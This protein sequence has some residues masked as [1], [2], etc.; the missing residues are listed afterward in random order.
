MILVGICGPIGSGKTTFAGLLTQVDPDH[1][2]HLETSG[3][4]TELANTF[5]TEL[6]KRLATLLTEPSL[7]PLSNELIAMLLPQLSNMAGKSISLDMVEI[8]AEDFTAHPDWY[9]KLFVYL[10]QAKSDPAI[11][12]V[13]ITITNKNNYRPLLQWIGGYFLYKLNNRLL[14]YEELLRRAKSTGPNM[15]I[16]AMTAPRQPA[17]AEFIQ[18]AGGKVFKIE[19]PGLV[20]DASDVTERHVAEIIPDTTITNDG[21]LTDLQSLAGKVHDDLLQDTLKPSYDARSVVH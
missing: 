9:E 19:R 8:T 15:Q 6:H 5:N 14:W 3:V 12:D 16:I 21:S 13:E 11:L 18:Q 20:S 7:V 2:L 4:V 1:S 17:E 10:Q